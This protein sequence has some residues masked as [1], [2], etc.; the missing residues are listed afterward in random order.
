MEE[1]LSTLKAIN[2]DGA[3]V[4]QSLSDNGYGTRTRNRSALSEVLAH[5]EIPR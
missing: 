3:G 1:G 5:E 4:K 2:V